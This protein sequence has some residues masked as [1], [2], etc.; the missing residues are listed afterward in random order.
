MSG[1]RFAGLLFFLPLA[2]LH[3]N[4]SLLPPS[5]FYRPP[6]PQHYSVNNWAGSQLCDPI[7]TLS[8]NHPT[9]GT[10]ATST[11]GIATQ[12]GLKGRLPFLPLSMVLGALSA[13]LYRGQA[14]WLSAEKIVH[15]VD[16]QSAFFAVVFVIV[17]LVL[18]TS[19]VAPFTASE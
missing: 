14:S 2:F 7:V 19:P 1:W 6:F 17:L 11:T 15:K 8:V 12:L 9:H 5:P 18:G 4:L 3:A 16:L 13:L 10:R